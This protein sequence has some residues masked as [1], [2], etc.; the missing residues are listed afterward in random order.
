MVAAGR[1]TSILGERY[2]LE[3]IVRVLIVPP[4]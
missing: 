2:S 3:L 4:P 1:Q